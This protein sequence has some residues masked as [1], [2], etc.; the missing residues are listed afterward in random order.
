MA[1]RGHDWLFFKAYWPQTAHCDWVSNPPRGTLPPPAYIKAE[2]TDRD[3]EP[4]VWHTLC[5]WVCLCVLFFSTGQHI[6]MSTIYS[7]YN[8][9]CHASDEYSKNKNDLKVTCSEVH[10]NLPQCLNTGF[11]IT[12]KFLLLSDFT[13]LHQGWAFIFGWLVPPALD[14]TSVKTEPPFFL[15][16]F[17]VIFGVFIL[18]VGLPKFVLHLLMS[19]TTSLEVAVELT[20]EAQQCRGGEPEKITITRLCSCVPIYQ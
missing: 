7:C 11:A 17:N 16:L 12:I 6:I 9:R 15:F 14:C 18:G 8:Y 19:T 2:E 5:I 13:A 3:C 1:W 10:C 4:E 20:K